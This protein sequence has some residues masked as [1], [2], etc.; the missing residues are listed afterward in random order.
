MSTVDNIPKNN[1]SGSK[2]LQVMGGLG[3]LCA[4]LIVMTYEGTADRIA[5]LKDEA[6]QQAV[7]SVL[8]GTASTQQFYINADQTISTTPSDNAATIFAGYDA[9]G[10]FTGVA[11][12]ASGRGYADVIR[13]LYGYDPVNEKVIG[14]YVLESKE[15]PGL[16]DKIE[17]DE[18]FLANFQSLDVELNESGD[19]LKNEVITVKSGEKTEEWQVDGI[20]GATISSRA[21]GAMINTSANERLQVIQDNLS[22]IQNQPE[23]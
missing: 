21:I 7:F 12:E 4:L 20:T 8:P 15:T 19:E 17:K 2:M 9:N 6:L 23:Q 10:E 3:A 11:V 1:T 22:V 18:S 13:I 5:Q 16:G 14:F